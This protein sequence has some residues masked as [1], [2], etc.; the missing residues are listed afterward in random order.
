MFRDINSDSFAA[1][2]SFLSFT[3]RVGEGHFTL[4]DPPY[5]QAAALFYTLT[6]TIDTLTAILFMLFIS[7]ISLFFIFLFPKFHQ[8][9]VYPRLKLHLFLVLITNRI[10]FI[11]LM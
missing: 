5:L 2:D 3:E 8:R 11:D 1:I 4:P 6:K 9:G 7:F 10:N